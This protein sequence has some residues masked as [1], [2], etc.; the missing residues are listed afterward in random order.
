MSINNR[1][2]GDEFNWLGD[3]IMEAACETNW[4]MFQE[5]GVNWDG[6]VEDLMAAIRVMKTA[7]KIWEKEWKEDMN[8]RL[9]LGK[10]YIAQ[11]FLLKLKDELIKDI[12]AAMGRACGEEEEEE[13]P[14]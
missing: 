3:H 4:K 13:G 9:R 14:E 8:D 6:T 1:N 7:L 5:R 12:I 11:K 10:I 2:D